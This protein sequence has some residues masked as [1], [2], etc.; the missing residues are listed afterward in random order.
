[1]NLIRPLPFL[2]R[3]CYPISIADDGDEVQ[4]LPLIFKDGSM[5]T[6]DH[7]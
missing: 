3:R 2:F 5:Y 4:T 7:D 1:M 6:I